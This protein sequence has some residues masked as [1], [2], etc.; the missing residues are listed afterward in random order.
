MDDCPVTTFS[1][2]K[3]VDWDMIDR[4]EGY[5]NAIPFYDDIYIQY[6]KNPVNLPL[7]DFNSSIRRFAH[8]VLRR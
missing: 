3:I 6:G 8:L 5:Q 1:I 4:S 2:E 7:I